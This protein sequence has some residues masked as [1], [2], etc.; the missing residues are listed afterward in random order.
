MYKSK[1]HTNVVLDDRPRSILDIIEAKVMSLDVGLP[2]ETDERLDSD[3]TDES[4]CKSAMLLA[5]YIKKSDWFITHEILNV[6][7]Y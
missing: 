7:N 3:E 1:N 5:F 2:I 4:D 6:I